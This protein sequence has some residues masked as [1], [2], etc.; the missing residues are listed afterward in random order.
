MNKW[1]KELKVSSTFSIWSFFF[2]IF[3]YTLQHMGPQFWDLSSLTRAG[4]CAPCIGGQSLNSWATG[5][6]L[7]FRWRLLVTSMCVCVSVAQ[8]CPLHDPMDCSLPGS[9]VQGILRQEYWSWVVI[10][11]SWPRHQTQISHFVGRFWAAREAPLVTRSQACSL[12][13]QF[14][15]S[16][17]STLLKLLL[18]FLGGSVVRIHLLMQEMWV[19][20]RSGKIPWR[21]K[22]QP[23][24]VFLPGKSHG[25]TSLVGYSPW[26]CKES[27]TTSD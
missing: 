24:P 8:P 13:P 9:S 23:T 27:D 11:F 10:P 3:G 25:Q 22:W 21:R 4:I 6:C 15:F 14:F 1:K 2:F 5:K 7:I 12:H 17:I 16:L 19:Q 18:G 26:G 20:P